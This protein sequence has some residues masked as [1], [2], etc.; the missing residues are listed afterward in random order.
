VQYLG[1]AMICM[2]LLR[3]ASENVYCEYLSYCEYLCYCTDTHEKSNWTRYR[4]VFLALTI[5]SLPSL[6]KLLSSYTHA[7][8]SW[9]TVSLLVLICTTSMILLH[10]ESR[11]EQ[12][13]PK[14]KIVSE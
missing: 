5:F 10:M 13:K 14:R 4:N 7:T 12:S 2:K 8:I 9:I 6:S 3:S 11:D 1:T